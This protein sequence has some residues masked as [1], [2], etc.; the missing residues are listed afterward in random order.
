[1][2][3]RDS[4]Q[5]LA[6]LTVCIHGGELDLGHAELLRRRNNYTAVIPKLITPP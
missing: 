3:N 2:E 5:L 1:M 6:H 4:Q